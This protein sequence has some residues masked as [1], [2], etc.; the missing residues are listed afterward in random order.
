MSL[1]SVIPATGHQYVGSIKRYTDLEWS[2]LF[3]NELQC[4]KAKSHEREWNSYNNFT[5]ILDTIYEN[6]E[7]MKMMNWLKCHIV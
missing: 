1:I 6:Y 5:S 2:A 3:Y 4:Q 7:C